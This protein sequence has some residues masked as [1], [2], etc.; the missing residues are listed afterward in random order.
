MDA[1]QTCECGTCPSVELCGQ[2]LLTMH[3]QYWM[4]LTAACLC[5][6]CLQDDLLDLFGKHASPLSIKRDVLGTVQVEGAHQRSAASAAEL[7][8]I[9]QEGM[10]RRSTAV[11]QMNFEVL[12]VPANLAQPESIARPTRFRHRD[13]HSQIT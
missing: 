4:L 12:S 6:C 7:L 10:R 1:L 8:A 11:T 5:V 3:L 13:Q 2:T 9:F